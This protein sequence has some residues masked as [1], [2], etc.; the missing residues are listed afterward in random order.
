[1]SSQGAGKKT[2]RCSN[3]ENFPALHAGLMRQYQEPW[4]KDD[5][6]ANEEK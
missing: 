5:I 4:N 3:H 2:V 1:M 6:T